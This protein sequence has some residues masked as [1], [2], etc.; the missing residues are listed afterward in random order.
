MGWMGWMGWLSLEGAIYR[1]PTVLIMGVISFQKIYGLY[2][3]NILQ[4]DLN[5]PTVEKLE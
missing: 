2:G 3:Q 1:A 5:G 4:S